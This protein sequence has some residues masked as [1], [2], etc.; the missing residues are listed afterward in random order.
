MKNKLIQK[1]NSMD[2]ILFA[3]LFGSYAENKADVHSDVDI[4]VYMKDISLDNQLE[5]NFELSKLL[6]KDVDLVVLN[7]VKNLFLLESIFQKGI[8]LKDSQNRLD[9]ELL[10][11]HDILDYKAFKKYL[12]AA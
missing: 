2:N 10:K 4:A 8:L 3:Y 6:K 11:E 7:S 1:M 5:V 12:D 9:F